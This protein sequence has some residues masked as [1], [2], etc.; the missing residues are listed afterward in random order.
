[1]TFN[2]LHSTF[3]IPRLQ[4]IIDVSRMTFRLASLLAVFPLAVLAANRPPNYDALADLPDSPAFAWYGGDRPAV[5]AA[6]DGGGAYIAHVHDT[7]RGAI[8]IKYRQRVDGIEVFRSE[9]N[10]AMTRDH[11]LIAT[12][13][14]LFEVRRLAAAFESGAESPHSKDEAIAIATAE[15]EGTALESHPA[16]VPF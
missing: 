14:Q 8:I 1:M 2:I 13:G 7:G 3:I 6:P 9:F 4:S 12:S 15:V 5:A 11:K 10:V 16:W